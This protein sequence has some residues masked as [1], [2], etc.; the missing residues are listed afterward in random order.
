MQFAVGAAFGR[1]ALWS[2]L[3]PGL[4]GTAAFTTAGQLIFRI[5]TRSRRHPALD[6]PPR[7]VARKRRPAPACLRG[8]AG[9]CGKRPGL[10]LAFPARRLFPAVAG[11]GSRGRAGAA[12]RLRPS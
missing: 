3:A 12:R 7:K 4:A 8:A 6:S 9:Q 10:P 2:H 1:T 5:K 11:F